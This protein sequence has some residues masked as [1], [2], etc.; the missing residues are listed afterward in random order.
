MKHWREFF[1]KW[2]SHSFLDQLTAVSHVVVIVAGL[3]GLV[4]FALERRDAHDQARREMALQFIA[5]SYT[6]DVR[7]A[8]RASNAYILAN[9]GKFSEARQQRAAGKPSSFILPSSDSGA[10]LGRLE[11]YDQLLVCRKLEQCDKKLIDSVFRTDMCDFEGWLKVILPQL[12]KNFGT[13]I[14]YRLHNYCAGASS[15]G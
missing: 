1:A 9:V 6:D 4:F 3:A 11:F 5:L 10:F 2:R 8:K 12:E 13:G 14:A 15:N 7:A